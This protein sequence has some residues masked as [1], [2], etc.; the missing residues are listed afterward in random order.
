M[1][2]LLFEDLFKKFNTE[3]KKEI[4]LVIKKR[5]NQSQLFDV[6]KLMNANSI[7]HGLF[8]SLSSGNWVVKRFKVEKKGVTQV[9][10]R[11]SYVA[12]M[13]MMT[14]LESHIEKSRKVSGPRAL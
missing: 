4:D 7:T 14:R 10:N 9:L 11:L 12:A 8:T 3:L 2:A 6:T 5:K 13:G 1:L